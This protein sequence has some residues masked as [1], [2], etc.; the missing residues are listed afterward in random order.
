MRCLRSRIGQY[1]SINPQCRQFA[2]PPQA[3]IWPPNNRIAVDEGVI[4]PE[5]RDLF[6]FAESAEEIW[7][8]ILRWYDKAGKPLLMPEE[9]Q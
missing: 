6:W 8:G 5:D 9:T 1:E 2:E 7:Q 3:V 4:D